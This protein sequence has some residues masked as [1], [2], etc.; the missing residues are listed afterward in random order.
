MT[1]DPVLP[2]H[3]HFDRAVALFSIALLVLV[4]FIIW[5]GDQLG[6]GVIAL[7]PAPAAAGVSV[8]SGIHI[9]FDQTLSANPQSLALTFNPPVSGTVRA[10]GDSLVFVPTTALQPNTAYTVTLPPGLESDQGRLLQHAVTWQF[11]TG[12]SQVLY[13]A[14]DANGHEQLF[15]LPINLD[16]LSAGETNSTPSQLTDSPNGIWDFTAAPDGSDILFSSLEMDGSSDLSTIAPGDQAPTLFLDCPRAVCSGVNWSPDQRFLAFSRRNASE[17]SSG[18]MSPPRLWLVDLQT[19]KAVPVFDDDQRLGFEPRWSADQTWLAYL[20]PDLGGVGAYNLTTQEERFYA[21]TTGETGVWHPQRNQLLI[22]V[23]KQ[24]GE[25]FVVH[26][27]L[28][29]PTTEEERDLSG[30]NN[31]VEDSSPVWSPDGE[32]IA[33]RRKELAGP[34]ATLGKQLWRMRTDGGDAAPLT[35]D[36]TVDHGQPAWS[37]DG[38]YLL[39]HK[40]PLK[41][42]DTTMSIWLLDVA[43][44][45]QWQLA[46]PG[47]RPVWM[48]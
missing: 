44:G 18:V 20:S 5:R 48:P 15:M 31:A 43:T 28:V 14:L 24:L 6:V 47:Q 7:S 27:L 32:W 9:R 34:R 25:R 39:F 30:E 38:R 19:S 35:S 3:S 26:L 11:Q 46:R 22:S 1:M 33:F 10:V 8:R 23:M 16:R 41:G 17:F 42:P 21:T 13:S 2:T 12:Q 36:A 29:D 40:L 4:G 45:E 37:P